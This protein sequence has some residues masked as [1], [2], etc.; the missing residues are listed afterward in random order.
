M[1]RSLVLCALFTLSFASL[2]GCSESADDG[3]SSAGASAA[4]KAAAGKKGK[5]GKNG[6][7]GGKKGK[8][9]GKK[10][11]KGGEKG[12]KGSGAAG[13][14]ANGASS[15]GTLCVDGTGVTD[16]WPGEYPAP[17]VQVLKDVTLKGHK[18]V[19]DPKPSLDCTLSPG[20]FHPWAK[21]NTSRFRSIDGISSYEV[22]KPFLVEGDKG[23]VTLAVGARVDEK[24]YMAEGMCVLASGGEDYRGECP[25]NGGNEDSFRVLSTGPKGMEL[26]KFLGVDCPE[27]HAAWIHVTDALFKRPEV[28]EGQVTGY[29]EIGPAAP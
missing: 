25:G 26:Q 8:K 27:G 20:L 29:G 18:D 19:C 4:G 1:I 13:V 21:G 11:K 12:K 2:A 14:P 16:W 6:K 17:V 22:L 24:S 15:A 5:K 28:T 10:G 23:D 9:G 7:K 3:K